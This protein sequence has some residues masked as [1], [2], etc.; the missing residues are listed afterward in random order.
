MLLVLIAA[1]SFFFRSA[2]ATASTYRDP[3][4]EKV[5]S[6][7]PSNATT[8]QQGSMVVAVRPPAASDLAIRKSTEERLADAW[9]TGPMLAPSAGGVPK[10]HLLIEPYFYDVASKAAD[11]FGSQTYVVYGLTKRL[12]VGALTTIGLNR[13]HHGPASR[14][15]GLGDQTLIFQYRLTEFNPSKSWLPTLAF[16]IQETF[17]TGRY[18]NLDRLSDGLGNGAYTTSVA[19]Y[20]QAYTRLSNG[21]LLRMRLNIQASFPGVAPVRNN[22]VYDTPVGFLG[23][24]RPGRS[25]NADLA[26]EYSLTKRWVLAFDIVAKHIERTRVHGTLVSGTTLQTTTARSDLTGVAPAI[27]YNFS[28]NYGILLGTRILA[29]RRSSTFTVTPALAVNCY[30]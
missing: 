21:R 4:Q 29:G 22:S 13:P 27:E 11:D 14:S 6:I 2:A 28:S 19:V 20:S 25:Y 12:S 5:T 10:G 24:A 18:D 8:E 1:Q 7:A 3:L 15:V 9:W 26:F 16:N 17:P 23:T 30:F